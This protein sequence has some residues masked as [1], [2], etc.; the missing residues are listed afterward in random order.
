MRLN[1]SSFNLAS[2]TSSYY[3][4]LAVSKT[5]STLVRLC[6]TSLTWM[7]WSHLGLK[8]INW[9]CWLTGNDSATT[10]ISVSFLS[11]KMLTNLWFLLF[12]CD[13]LLRFVVYLSGNWISSGVF[14][15][16]VKTSPLEQR[17]CVPHQLIEK[18]ISKLIQMILISSSSNVTFLVE[19]I[20]LDQIALRPSL[21][22]TSISI[23]KEFLHISEIFL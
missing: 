13:N 11:Q 10:F 6:W 22:P 12:K 5:L 18:I 7:A 4:C 2:D 8:S 9:F 23:I 16:I 3:K 15:F 14:F 19:I 20:Q 1:N 17:N 21:S